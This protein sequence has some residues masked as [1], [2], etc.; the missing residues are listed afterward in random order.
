MF[1]LLTILTILTV[2]VFRSRLV[3]FVLILVLGQRHLCANLDFVASCEYEGFDTRSNL[4]ATSF[5]PQDFNTTRP[6]SNFSLNSNLISTFMN[7]KSSVTDSRYV[8]IF[9]EEPLIFFFFSESGHE[10]TPRRF[11]VQCGLFAFTYAF[12]V[13][14]LPYYRRFYLL[15]YYA[16]RTRCRLSLKAWRKLRKQLFL[17]KQVYFSQNIYGILVML[18]LLCG[19]VHPHPGPVFPNAR[20]HSEAQELNVA[21]WN[22][23]TLLETKRSAG[24]PTAIVSRELARYNIDIAALSETRILGDSIISEDAGGYTFFLKGKPLGDKCYHGVGFAIRTKLVICLEGKYPIGINERL[25]TMCL[26]LDKFTLSII[27]AYAPTLAS[28]DVSKAEFY[29]KLSESIKSVPSSHKLLVMGDFNARVGADYESWE[30]VIGRHGVGNENSNGTLLLSMCSQLEL[31]ITNT[32]FQQANRH[33]TTWMHPGTKEWHMI[34]YVITR[35]RDARDVHHTRAMCGSCTW[36]DHRLV[37]CK[38]ALRVK[39]HRHRC[40]LKPVRKLN[41]ARLKSAECRL[42]LGS[43]LQEAYASVDSAETRAVAVW[44]TFK[45]TTLKVAEEVLGPIERKHCDWFDENDSLIKPLLE[46]LHHLHLKVIEDK[47]DVHKAADY[48]ACKQQTQQLLRHMKNT[49]WR[50]RAAVLQEAADTRNYKTFYQEL[51]AVHGPQ[52][53]ASPCVR[54]TDGSLLTEPTEV[55]NRWAE[56]F[57]GV[58]NQDSQFDES[59]LL[60]FP[61]FDTNT[62]LDALPTLEEVSLSIKQLTSGKAPGADGIPPD[63]FKHGGSCIAEELLRLF[64]SGRKASFRKTLKMQI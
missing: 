2:S 22:V 33:K 34:D 58:L 47:D 61:Q 20:R 56:H 32:I 23:R 6:N 29:D 40:R 53:K 62:S 15:S 18:L 25:M 54:S 21:S 41:T 13:W 42:S 16:E 36:S 45:K 55:L 8:L 27:S 28:S 50:E 17:R 38:L 44:D 4:Q 35:Q 5:S 52:Y 46:R 3:V 30:K 43:K 39:M 31:I 24:R 10:A 37:K 26:P 57:K 19:D 11:Y 63:I 9:K 60:D 49:W 48:R 51:K 64:T 14:Y 1:L 59:V 12:L 7:L